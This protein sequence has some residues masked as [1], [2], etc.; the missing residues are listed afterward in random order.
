VLRPPAER[1]PA[2]GQAK[3]VRQN[4]SGRAGQGVRGMDE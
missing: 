2:L 4:R 3:P 1:V